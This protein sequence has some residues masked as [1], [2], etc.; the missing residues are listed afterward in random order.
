MTAR[1]T[2]ETDTARETETAREAMTVRETD[3]ARETGTLRLFHTGY[4]AVPRPDPTVGRPDAD[5]GAGFYLSDDAEFSKRWARIRRGRDTVLNEYEF[6]LDGLNVLLLDRDEAWYRLIFQNRAGTVGL[7]ADRDW[8]VVIG[9]IANDTLY[10][11]GGLLTSG[12]LTPAQALSLY[13]IGPCYRQIA[14]KSERA[15]ARLRFRSAT[16]LNPEEVARYRDLVR[17][18]EEEYLAALAEAAEK[19]FGEED[20]V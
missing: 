2:R 8:D 14:V 18:E 19:M 4:E 15:A 7:P 20:P 6:S 17:R 9:P 13:R 5:F 12:L 11:T 1:E 10:D 3:T 16:V